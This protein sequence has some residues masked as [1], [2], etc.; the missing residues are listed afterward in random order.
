[1]ISRKEAL[2][3]LKKYLRDEDNIKYS[4]AVEAVLREIAKKLERD[5]DLWGLTGLLHNLDYEFTASNP[6]QRGTLS[7]QLL[8]DLLPERGVDAIRANN[9]VHTDYMPTTAI[10][11]SLIAVVAVTGFIMEVARNMPNKKIDEITL[12]KLKAKFV[13]STFAT[14]YNR[15]KI[16]LC[17]D[18]GIDLK[19]FL[20]ISLNSLKS[21]NNNLKL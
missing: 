5:V 14:K 21:I 17:T 12:D 9:Y 1:M 4:I 16:K 19:T 8:E 18:F 13:D 3:L 11:K 6:E 10:D 20:E 2:I 7:S 15:N